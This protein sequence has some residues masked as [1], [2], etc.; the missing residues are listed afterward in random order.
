MELNY[1]SEMA[2]RAPSIRG[3]TLPVTLPSYRSLSQARIVV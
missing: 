1:Y 2:Y 3:V